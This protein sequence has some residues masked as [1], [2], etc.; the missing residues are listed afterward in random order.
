MPLQVLIYDHDDFGSDDFLGRTTVTLK[1]LLGADPVPRWHDLKDSRGNKESE[2]RGRVQLVCRWRHSRSADFAPFDLAEDEDSETE[3]DD[4]DDD[5]D[6][7]SGARGGEG[8]G[9]GGG[10][11]PDEK[12]KGG[13][14]AAA[15]AAAVEKGAKEDQLKKDQ[16]NYKI[17]SGDYQVCLSVGRPKG[18]LNGPTVRLTFPSHLVCDDF[19]SCDALR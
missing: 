13:D 11:D 15:E 14:K 12:S 2:T 7:R 3:T 8:G 17:I 9:G 4:D 5:N 10:A 1:S 19:I 6:D 18:L 16:E